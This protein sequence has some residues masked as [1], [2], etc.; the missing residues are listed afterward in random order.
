MSLDTM[1]FVHYLQLDRMSRSVT[2]QQFINQS[3]SLQVISKHHISK[4]MAMEIFHGQLHYLQNMDHRL[5][6]FLRL[7]A[8]FLLLIL[9]L[10]EPYQH[11]LQLFYL[12]FLSLS[13]LQQ[14]QCFQWINRSMLSR[15][16]YQSIDYHDQALHF[17]SLPNVIILVL[18]DVSGLFLLLT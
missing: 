2:I 6:T 17:L 10:W 13:N 16:F 5:L 7:R 14:D 18:Y 4:T 15:Y 3:S 12:F 1:D 8:A 9:S 11:E